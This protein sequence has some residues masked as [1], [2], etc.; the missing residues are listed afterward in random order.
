M[1]GKIILWQILNGLCLLLSLNISAQVAPPVPYTSGCTTCLTQYNNAR[2]SY[3]GAS[4]CLTTAYLNYQQCLSTAR[5][6]YVNCRK[7][8]FT[9]RVNTFKTAHDNAKA[10]ANADLQPILELQDAYNNAPIEVANLRN[11]NLTG[12]SFTKYLYSSNPATK[13]YPGVIQKI[14]LSSTSSTFLSSTNTNSIVTKDS[15]Y[16][17]EAFLKYYTGNL[18]E[19][20][21][22]GGVYTSCIW[23]YNNTLPIVKAIGADQATLLAAYNA[24]GGNLSLLRSQ[25]S[26]ANAQIFTYTYS[27]VIGMTGETNPQGTV[28]SYEYD[29]L[30]RLSI[31]R[32]Q[33]NN[34]IKKFSYNYSLY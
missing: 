20:L 18:V 34:V 30:G 26:L 21:A 32:N 24:V 17:D 4:S 15:R 13:V 28:T 10:G 22:K 14:N 25:S 29:A 5:I 2:T 6:N 8:N 12:A 33:N 16:A 11:A 7:T 3:G 27:P 1:K 23:G 9:D 31:I 19:I